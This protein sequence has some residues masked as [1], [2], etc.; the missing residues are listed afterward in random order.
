MRTDRDIRY[1]IGY[2]ECQVKYGIPPS[3]EEV[4]QADKSESG[5]RNGKVVAAA[6]D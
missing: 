6:E 2:G 3:D 4:E 5:S 1:D